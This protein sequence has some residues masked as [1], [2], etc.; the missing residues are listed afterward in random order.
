MKK[1]YFLIIVALILGLVLT[2]CFLSNL[3][4]V[5]ATDQSGI[6]YLTKN[7]SP[8]PSTSLVGLW[9]FD[10]DALDSSGNDNDGDV[11]GAT[12]G[13]PGKFGNALSF[14]GV[15]DYVDCGNDASLDITTAITIEAWVYPKSAGLNN[16]GRI[17]DK[18]PAP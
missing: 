6:A 8:I 15:N 11:Y 16:Y 1:Y 9:H 4:Q 7:G 12:A 2:G 10:G 3:G 13:V 17:T 5:P 14:D 18:H